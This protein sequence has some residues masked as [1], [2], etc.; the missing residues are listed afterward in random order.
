MAQA[1]GGQRPKARVRDKAASH[2]RIVR[3]AA[4]AIRRDGADRLSV[5]ALMEQA[6]LT[7]GGF[8]RHFSSRD[9]LIDEA[10]AAALAHGGRYAG[11]GGGLPPDALRTV[12]GAYLSPAH[13]DHPEAGCAVAALAADV[14]RASGTARA[15]YTAQVRDNIDFLARAIDQHNPGSAGTRQEAITALAA[16]VGA[17]LMARATEGTSLSDEIL[18]TVRHALAGTRQDGLPHE[19]QDIPP[20]HP[21]DG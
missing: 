5:A 9:A 21:G 12:V 15:A 3:A 17:I 7:H 14:T 10:V 16:L 8:Y 19:Q 6:G 18:A 13:R 11:P 20:G 4:G 1:R 2:E